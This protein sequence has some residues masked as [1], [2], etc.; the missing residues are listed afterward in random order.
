MHNVMRVSNSDHSLHSCCRVITQ[1]LCVHGRPVGIQLAN[2][3]LKLFTEASFAAPEKTALAY[4]KLHLRNTNR[5][6]TAKPRSRSRIRDN[7]G[8]MYKDRTGS[9][10]YGQLE[11]I[12]LFESNQDVQVFAKILYLP[13]ARVQEGLCTDSVTDARLNDHIVTLNTPRYT[14][15][16]SNLLPYCCC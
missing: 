9:I 1:R 10:C 5:F 7:S 12:F 3:E 14:K 13:P 4:S 2:Q 8:V 6:I 16:F 15:K 11:N